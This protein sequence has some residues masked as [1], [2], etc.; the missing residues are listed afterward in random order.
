ME[1][2]FV[3]TEVRQRI[4][5][6]RG[7]QVMLDSDLAQLY[8]VATKALKRAVRRNIQRFPDDFM[9]ELTDNELKSLRC[10][11]GTSSVD[12]FEV[13][14]GARYAPFAFSESGIAMLS[15]VL[16]SER[17][18]QINIEIMRLFIQLRSA[19]RVDLELTKRVK[20][21]E[22]RM[23]QVEARVTSMPVFERQHFLFDSSKNTNE[24]A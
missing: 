17:A 5:S 18:V 13:R 20:S 8:Q 6:I 11:I 22:D 21:L 15:S 9:F 7:S 3:M 23:T 16:N 19:S 14:G 12:K 4:Y 24:L 2:E 1:T 10:Q